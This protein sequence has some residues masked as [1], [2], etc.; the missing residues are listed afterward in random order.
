LAG[1]EVRFLRSQASYDR[2]W[3]KTAV[4][5]SG[6]DGSYWGNNGHAETIVS[7]LLLTHNGHQRTSPR[8]GTGCDN[9]SFTC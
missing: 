7:G 1:A 3:H 9:L 4:R 8:A 5:S 2:F 6:S